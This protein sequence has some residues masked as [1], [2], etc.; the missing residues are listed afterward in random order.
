[1]SLWTVT[2]LLMLRLA[3]NA[4]RAGGSAVPGALN[5]IW[6]GLYQSPTVPITPVTTLAGITEANYDGYSRQQVVWFPP[7]LSSSGPVLLAAQDAY[8]TPSDGLSSNLITGVFMADSF[9]GGGLLAAAALASPGRVLSQVTDALKVQPQF[10][11]PAI[12]VYGGPAV[13]S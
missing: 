1:M 6:L 2:Y 10:A 7:F 5:G 13:V 9:Y 8:F 3:L 4:I 11:L 12:S